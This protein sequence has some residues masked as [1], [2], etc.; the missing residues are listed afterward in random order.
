MTNERRGSYRDGNSTADRALTILQ[1]FTETRDRVSATEMAEHLG[2]SRSTSYRYAQTLI[3]SEFLVEEPG[4]G[5]RLGPKIMELARIARRGHGLSDIA[6][7]VMRD[8]AGELRETVLLTK[9]IGTTI[10]CL[11]REEWPGLIVRLSYERGSRLSLNAGAS[12]L[13]LLAW[14]PEDEVRS[15]L[16][17]EEL[18]AYTAKTLTETDEI[19]E[20]LRQIKEDGYIVARGEVDPQVM[21]LAVP[22]FDAA[23]RV[24]AALSVVTLEARIPESHQSA[25]IDKL[26]T[27]A[28]SLTEQIRRD[29][30]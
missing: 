25:L 7:P 27:R 8:L 11:E 9:R 6:V 21:G 22:I 26:R 5:F 16:D 29:S 12:A 23:G 24:T 20:R 3:S 15:L 14:L 19:I 13:V 28:D 2:V 30:E 17:A 1:M 18:H 4:S 10:L